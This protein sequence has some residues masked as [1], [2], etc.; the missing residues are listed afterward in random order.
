MFFI[1]WVE[2]HFWREKLTSHFGILRKRSCI[3]SIGV[4]K[5]L[6][7]AKKHSKKGCDHHLTWMLGLML[8]FWTSWIMLVRF[9]LFWYMK[10]LEKLKQWTFFLTAKKH[11]YQ[12]SRYLDGSFHQK[13]HVRKISSS[14]TVYG[15]IFQGI[16]LP[17]W[18]FTRN[19]L[20]G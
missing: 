10:F 19:F 20:R 3:S 7:F 6:C 11:T 14:V 8:I 1:F 16:L 12:K 13:Y 5:N 15:L 9:F 4:V 18:K 2:V 17:G